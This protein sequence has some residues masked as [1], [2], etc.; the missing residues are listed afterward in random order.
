MGP[1]PQETFTLLVTFKEAKFF[2]ES[3]IFCA[4]RVFEI[5]YLRPYLPLCVL[6]GYASLYFTCLCA[7]VSYKPLCLSVLL[8]FVSLCLVFFYV[9]SLTRFNFVNVA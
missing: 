7:Y 8:D 5:T 6:C 4:V 2:M 3:L 1:N 9:R